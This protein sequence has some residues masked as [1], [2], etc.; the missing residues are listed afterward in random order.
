MLD[1]RT[2]ALLQRGRERQAKAHAERDRDR[3]ANPVSPHANGTNLEARERYVRSA[4][5]GEIEG[6]RNAR[7]GERNNSTYLAAV[8]LGNLVGAGALSRGEA[9]DRLLDAALSSGLPE[10]EARKT[11][12]SG[13]R[14]GEREPR[15]LSSV[16]ALQ[17][18]Y[19]NGYGNG[20]RNPSSNDQRDRGSEDPDLRGGAPL[21][22]P[23]SFTQSAPASPQHA[24]HPE[25]PA[26]D[27]EIARAGGG[28]SLDG[29]DLEAVRA[30]LTLALAI[31]DRALR[32][33]A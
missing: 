13:L 1:D 16:G 10:A 17:K 28:F 30:A 15:D 14:I 4:I 5:E 21:P 22:G 7:E 9:E 6:V 19:S 33:R 12:R 18:R 31:V 2:A 23:G 8:K 24:G 32:E 27:R 20:Y 25:T 29:R 26:L 3:R 11:I